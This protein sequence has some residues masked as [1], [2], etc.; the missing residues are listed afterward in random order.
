MPTA[1]VSFR[2]MVIALPRTVGTGLAAR[3]ADLDARYRAAGLDGRGY[4]RQFLSLGVIPEPGAGGSNPPFRGDSR[5]LDGDQTGTAAGQPGVMGQMPV[6]NHAVGCG[7]LAHGRDGNAIAQGD[8]FQLKRG[9]QFRHVESLSNG[10]IGEVRQRPLGHVRTMTV[11][12]RPAGLGASLRGPGN[13]HFRQ[14]Y[15]D[16]FAPCQRQMLWKRYEAL[17]LMPS[18]AGNRSCV[19]PADNCR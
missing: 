13:R 12:W 6:V 9:E 18:A 4:G 19:T 2:N 15:G 14:E 1:G 11:P 5:R 3:M 8:G 10:W 16:A 17:S 7:I